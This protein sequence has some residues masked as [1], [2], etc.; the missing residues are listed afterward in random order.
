LAAKLRPSDIDGSAGAEEE[1]ARIVR[2]IRRRWPR[3]RILL[4]ADSA[5]AREPL[6]AWCEANR[7]DYLF[8]LA[9]N[10]RLEAEIA[11]DLAWAADDH[12]RS[13]QPARRFKDFFYATLDSWS[14]RRRVVAKAEHLAKGANPRFLVTSLRRAEIDARPLYEDLY[15]A[16]GEAENRIK[17]QQLDLFA[18]RTSS[19]TM[20]AN[21]LRLWFAAMAYVLLD[22][23]RR[24]GLRHTRLA[25]ATC[26]TIRSK[27]LKI[28][29][30]VRASVRR[31]YLA[32]A[33][34]CP[35]RTEFAL[36]HIALRRAYDTS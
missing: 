14:R 36:A 18:D 28:G 23:L 2:H 25:D 26:G 16:R 32:M 24:V 22:A 12:A 13:G 17:E 29:A 1:V 19:A 3:V 15:C 9:R 30:R 8:G 5:F 20:A 33:S 27:L 35:Y 34:G 7:V 31:L 10:R 4:R 21:Q 6:M 11:A